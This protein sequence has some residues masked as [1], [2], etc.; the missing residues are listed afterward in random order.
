MASVRWLRGPRWAAGRADPRLSPSLT[1]ATW[2][3]LLTPPPSWAE[4][5][6]ASVSAGFILSELFSE[7]SF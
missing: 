1:L 2:V 4:P 6:G 5:V 7:T 3:A